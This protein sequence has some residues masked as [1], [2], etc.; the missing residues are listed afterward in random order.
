MSRIEV[1]FLAC[2]AAAA[3][4]FGARTVAEISGRAFV[5]SAGE[6]PAGSAGRPRDVDMEKL[7]RLLRGGGL[8]DREAL[9]YRKAG[10]AAREGGFFSASRKFQV[11][12]AEVEV[13]IVLAGSRRGSEEGVLG[14]AGEALR[15]AAEAPEGPDGRSEI[16]KARGLDL[17]VEELRGAGVEGVMARVGGCMRLFGRSPEGGPWRVGVPHPFKPGET[18]A[19][20]WVSSGAVAAAR[21]ARKEGEAVSAAAAARDAVSA[22][23]WAAALLDLGFEG[24]SRLPAGVE[25]MIILGPADA[26]RVEMTEGFRRLLAS[27]PDF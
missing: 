5:E 2:V 8:S 21:H 6:A 22:E 1:L 14:A 12:G 3:A 20:L 27:D 23:T 25:A 11:M 16:A 24:L 4:V 19:R 15:R 17:V 26:P 9:Y 10:A 7:G 13:T 18:C